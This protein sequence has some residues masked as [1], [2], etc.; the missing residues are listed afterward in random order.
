MP[1]IRLRRCLMHKTRKIVV[2]VIVILIIVAVILYF[3]LPK[4]EKEIFYKTE[5]SEFVEKYSEKYNIDKY[6]IFAVIRTES[7]FDKK[8]TS[9]VGARGLMQIMPDAFDWV[10]FRLKDERETVFDDMYDP[11]LNIEYCSYLLSYLI[12][13]FESEETAI[14]AYHAGIAQVDDWLQNKDISSDGKN[15]DNNPS[16][17]TAHYVDKVMSAYKSYKNLYDKQ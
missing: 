12:E 15:I 13:R 6:L 11:E 3:V 16:K 8:A 5:Y 2:L 9:D 1:Q 17:A 10:K 4:A 7:N 14:A